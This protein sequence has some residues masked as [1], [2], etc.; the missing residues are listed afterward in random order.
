MPNSID[1]SRREILVSL[2]VD[3]CDGWYTRMSDADEPFFETMENVR[4]RDV[5]KDTVTD[6][7]QELWLLENRGT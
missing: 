3:G 4:E 5:S 2:I 1:D 7:E 6:D